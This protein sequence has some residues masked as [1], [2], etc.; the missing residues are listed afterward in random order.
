MRSDRELA[1]RGMAV[2]YLAAG[3][4]GLVNALVLGH[5]DYDTL[6]LV[7]ISAVG[8]LVPL[9]LVRARQVPPFVFQGLL[10]VG[11]AAVTAAIHFTGGVPNSAA[12]LYLFVA[13]YAAYFFSAATAAIHVGIVAALYALV[14]ALTPPDFPAVGNWATTIVTVALAAA[15][16]GLLRDRLDRTMQRLGELAETDVLTGIANRRGWSERVALEL[17]RA[18]RES[19]PLTAALI[20]LDGFKAYNDTRGH[21]AGDRLLAAC[22]HAWSGALRDVDFLARFGG[23]EFAVLLPDCSLAAAEAVLSRLLDATPS[24]ARATVGAAEWV[25]GESVEDTLRRADQA[26]YERKRARPAPALGHRAA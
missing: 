2:L 5:G 6:S 17:A 8:F 1:A 23:D 21:E 4:L 7:A 16:V 10:L 9:A 3:V 18:T 24:P 26:L 15:C 20:D 13:L 14:I 11:S 25:P 12:M 22:A 19:H